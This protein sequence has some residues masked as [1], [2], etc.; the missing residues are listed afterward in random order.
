MA[1]VDAAR[2]VAGL[3]EL[4]RLTGDEDGAQRVAWTDTWITR[5]RLARGASSTGSTA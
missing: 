5:A 3:K 1:D 4:R 2:A